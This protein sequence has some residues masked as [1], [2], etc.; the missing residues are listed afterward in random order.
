[1]EHLKL[2]IIQDVFKIVHLINIKILQDIVIGAISHVP[3]A[4]VLLSIS[5]NCVMKD[6]I[7]IE[8]NAI[9]IHV[10]DLL[11]WL[12]MIQEYANNVN[13]VVKYVHHPSIVQYVQVD[14][15]YMKDGAT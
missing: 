7:S 3:H 8:I 15:I 6:H 14:S 12:I 1:M 13:G 5:V 10:L 11:I 9:I 2:I 4:L